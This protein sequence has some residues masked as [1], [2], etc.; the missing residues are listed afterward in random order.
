M[1]WETIDWYIDL[2]DEGPLVTELFWEVWNGV[3]VD[4]VYTWQEVL[5]CVKLKVEGKDMGLVDH[6]LLAFMEGT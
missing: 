1:N 2:D 5:H 6:K 3:P 4:L